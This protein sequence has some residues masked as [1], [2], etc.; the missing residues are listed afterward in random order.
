MSTL[1][2]S[3][4]PAP[5]QLANQS[6]RQVL[7][8]CIVHVYDLCMQH[9]SHS[10]FVDCIRSGG[11]LIRRRPLSLNRQSH[12][13]MAPAWMLRAFWHWQ[14]P[15][16]AGPTT[17]SQQPLQ[18]MQNSRVS[19]AAAAVEVSILVWAILPQRTACQHASHS[20]WPCNRTRPTK[21]TYNR[22]QTVPRCACVRSGG[23]HSQGRQRG[24]AAGQRHQRCGLWP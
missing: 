21:Q 11:K 22:H 4:R 17:Q 14:Q 8:C 10:Y 23:A 16:S 6:C 20:R 24:A 1:S 19:I 15:L 13:Q 18:R 12:W 7:S 5:S 9:L 3:I 2:S